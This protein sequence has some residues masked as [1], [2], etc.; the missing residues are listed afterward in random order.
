MMSTLTRAVLNIGTSSEDSGIVFK[1]HMPFK[2]ASHE[3]ASSLGKEPLTQ[4]SKLY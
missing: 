1:K 3:G 4:A 2:I